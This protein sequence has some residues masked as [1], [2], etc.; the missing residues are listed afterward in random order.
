MTWRALTSPVWPLLLAAAVAL[1]GCADAGPGRPPLLDKREK[2]EGIGREDIELTALL[3]RTTVLNLW[4]PW[5][6]PCLAEM[7]ALERLSGRL[8]S[9]AFAV[10]G[11][12][13]D[14]RFLAEEFLAEHGIS[15]ANY[16]DGDRSV[17]GGL[18][19]VSSFPQT[20]VFGPDGRELLRIPGYQDWD[21]PAVVDALRGLAGGRPMTSREGA[22]S[23]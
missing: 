3:G 10:V 16:F 19:S 21:D 12:T 5:C 20:L 4:A 11:V 23:G 15:F 7:P 9:N 17:V 6:G 22:D 8:D 2:L 14:D 18:F 1:V 13:V